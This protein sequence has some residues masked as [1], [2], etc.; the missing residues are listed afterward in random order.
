VRGKKGKT[1]LRK[2]E[3][4]ANRE[5]NI[6][7]GSGGGGGED[8]SKE[9]LGVDRRANARKKKGQFANEEKKRN[10]PSY[11]KE[12]VALEKNK[13]HKGES[14]ET[15][16]GRNSNQGGMGGGKVRLGVISNQHG[17][18]TV[19]RGRKGK[20]IQQGRMQKLSGASGTGRKYQRCP[21]PSSVGGG[22]K[23]KGAK[24]KKKGWVRKRESG[25]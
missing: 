24:E 22:A 9:K 13:G 23:K 21:T 19:P 7:N 2:V 17:N 20:K 10:A 14:A 5:K 8:V 12:G 4:K 25:S 3:P 18:H 16:T 11:E 6:V 15:C 1:G